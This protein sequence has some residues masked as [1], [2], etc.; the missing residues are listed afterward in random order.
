MG[1]HILNSKVQFKSNVDVYKIITYFWM[2]FQLILGNVI[3]NSGLYYIP[4]DPKY[5]LEIHPK[6][7]II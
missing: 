5:M 3:L 7:V 4:Q 2:N 1:I 6:Y